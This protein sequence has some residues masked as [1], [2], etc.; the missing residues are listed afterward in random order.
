[1]EEEQPK[2]S[3]RSS[4]AATEPKTISSQKYHADCEAVNFKVVK[5]KM[6]RRQHTAKNLNKIGLSS[7][8]PSG[9]SIGELLAAKQ[10]Q[11]DPNVSA[12]HGRKQ[13][14]FFNLERSLVMMRRGNN[15]ANS[16]I[17]NSPRE[18]ANLEALKDLQIV[19]EL[20]DSVPDKSAHFDNS[21][22]LTK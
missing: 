21:E 14:D 1:M 15:S 11:T 12:V 18:E 8:N 20:A 13:N 22:F 4:D 10:G 7:K 6:E 17:S 9:E 16:E 2:S 3:G 19:D 5:P